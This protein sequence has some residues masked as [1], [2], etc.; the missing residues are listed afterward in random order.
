MEITIILGLIFGVVLTSFIIL[1]KKLIEIYE[2]VDSI[3]T[4]IS[5]M[6]YDI[7][8]NHENLIKKLEHINARITA[9]AYDN[10]KNIIE[11]IRTNKDIVVKEI[12]KQ[13][14]I[15]SKIN[16]TSKTRKYTKDE[17]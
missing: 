5:N 6:S 3:L 10:S 11:E 13:A 17:K 9:E 15:S 7:N 14:K 8:N 2:D 4:I 16:S 1:Y 12:T